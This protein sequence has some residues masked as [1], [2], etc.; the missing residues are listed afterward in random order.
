LAR[1]LSGEADLAVAPQ[2]AAPPELVQERLFRDRVEL[3]GRE[4]HSLAARAR[5][6]WAQVLRHPFVTLTPDFTQQ[7]QADLFRHAP[8]LVLQPAHEVSLITTALGMVRWGGGITAQPASALGL[9]QAHG[10]VA[11]PIVSP[12]VYREV[13][14]YTL[15]ARVL[16]PAA[17]RFAA[18]LREA[19][20]AGAAPQADASLAAA[21]P[22]TPACGHA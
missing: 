22:A 13:S 10:L 3:I 11:R 12:R 2:R 20:A 14:L 5:L 18:F 9:A 17:Q 19:C 1:T 8:E 15:R 21:V 16:S 4:D 6:A 7:L